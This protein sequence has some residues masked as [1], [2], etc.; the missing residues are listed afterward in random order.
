[1]GA[2]RPTVVP[3]TRNIYRWRG[4]RLPGHTIAVRG[5]KNHSCDQSSLCDTA[6]MH[7]TIFIGLV[8][9]AGGSWRYDSGFPLK[10]GD[11]QVWVHVHDSAFNVQVHSPGEGEVSLEWID[12]TWLRTSA[13]VRAILDI[14]GFHLG[15]SLDIELISAAVDNNSDFFPGLFR[16]W[17]GTVREKVSSELTSPYIAQAASHPSFRHALADIR[18]AQRLDDDTAFYC[19]RVVEDLRQSYVEEGDSN[20]TASWDRLRSD[21]GLTRDELRDLEDSATARRHGEVKVVDLS[22]KM[23]FVNLARTL[24]TRFVDRRSSPPPGIAANP[25]SGVP[26]N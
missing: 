3:V 23:E 12:E 11:D 14:L 5:S 7:V 19:Y 4:L 26:A 22:K 17:P 15:A 1:V 10:H 18:Q 13:I 16:P 25:D 2:A 8:H 6:V 24:V 20:R 21:L 9:P